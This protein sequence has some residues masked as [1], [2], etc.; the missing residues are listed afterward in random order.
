MHGDWVR[1]SFVMA[2]TFRLHDCNRTQLSDDPWGG[3]CVMS[4]QPFLARLIAYVFVFGFLLGIH[5]SLV[6]SVQ[7]GPWP[8]LDDFPLPESVSLCCEPIPLENRRVWEMLDREFTI[9]VWDRAQ[10]FLWLKRAG[11]YFPHIEKKLAEGNMPEDLKYLAVAESSLL[12]YVGSSKGAKGTWQLMSQTA[13]RNGLRK[14]R[15]VDERL[16][17]EQSTEAA[18]K[19]LKELKDEFGTWT[20]AMAAYNCGE[21][22]LRKEI[23]EQRI[24]EYYRLN[25]PRETERFIFRITAIKIIM[26]NPERYG[27]SLSH[28]RVYKPVECDSVPVEIEVPLHMTDVAAGLDTDFKVLKELNPQI[29]GYYL[30]TGHYAL[31]VPSGEGFRMASVLKQLTLAA[32]PPGDKNLEPGYVVVRQGDTLSA[33]AERT[34]VSVAMLRR[35]NG[36]QGSRIMVGQKLGL[37]AR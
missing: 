22:R 34:G 20:L 25:L 23:A 27:Y 8:V 28:Q 12:T 3:N 11:R 13:R 7:E 10:V 4:A 21:V 33:I 26:E 19:Y 9:M 24:S 29:S 18:M 35:A 36:I 6:L 14:D 2:R 30:P 5:P 16:N 15:V 31:R 17:F 1:P 37:E 32:S